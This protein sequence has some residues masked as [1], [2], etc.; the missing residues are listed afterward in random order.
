MAM[1]YLFSTNYSQL[2]ALRPLGLFLLSP[3]DFPQITTLVSF[4]ASLCVKHLSP[5]ICPH[6]PLQM[7]LYCCI[8]AHNLVKFKNISIIHI[9]PTYI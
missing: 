7:L 2:T 5:L 3:V 4:L 1:N 9:I 6:S 8:V